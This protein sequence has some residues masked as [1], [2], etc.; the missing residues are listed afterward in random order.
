MTDESALTRA[1]D[2]RDYKTLSGPEQQPPKKRLPRRILH[3]SDGIL[4]EYSTEEEE[5]E[6]EK[7]AKEEEES[8]KTAVVDPRTLRWLP[9]MIW[10]GTALVQIINRT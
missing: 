8:K 3:F 1:P 5:E 7:K 9:W 10:L 6:Q 2:Q 4:E